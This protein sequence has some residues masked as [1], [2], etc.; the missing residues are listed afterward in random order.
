M[1]PLVRVVDVDLADVTAVDW[2]LGPVMKRPVSEA[3]K[4]MT[5]LMS[6]VSMP[7]RQQVKRLEI[8][9]TLLLSDRFGRLAGLDEADHH[10]VLHHGLDHGGVDGVHADVVLAELAGEGQHQR[11]DAEL[12]GVVSRGPA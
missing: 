1:L 9:P 7:R 4:I 12:R 11:H 5:S 10:V 2:R 3:R 8:R 6:L